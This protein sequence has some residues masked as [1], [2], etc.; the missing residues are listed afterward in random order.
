MKKYLP[1]VLILIIIVG[2][3]GSA[4]KVSAE[5]YQQCVERT[6]NLPIDTNV[7]PCAGLQ[8][9]PGTVINNNVT[10]ATPKTPDP[11]S[12]HL[13]QP[14]PGVSGDFSPGPTNALG[15]YL[16]S[17][18]TLFIGLCAVVAVV[19]IVIGGIEW[20][21]SELISK[22][23]AA[24]E[25]IW[26]AV[27]GLLLALGSYALL[28][29][30]NPD[31]LNTN[32]DIG[33]VTI[34]STIEQQIK[35][36]VDIRTSGIQ[37]IDGKPGAKINFKAEA[38]PV[39]LAVEGTT[40]V[41]AAYLLAIFDQESSSGSMAFSGCSSSNA[42]CVKW[43]PGTGDEQKLNQILAAIGKTSPVNVSP[44]GT[45]GGAYGGCMGY[46]QVCPSEWIRVGGLGK[47]PWNL[48]DSMTVAANL[49]VRE[50]GYNQNPA[51]SVCKYFGSCGGG[52]L[53]NYQASVLR[54]A[55]AFQDRINK[56]DCSA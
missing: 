40:G 11:A 48:N 17:M 23:E 15:S 2:F 33:D 41:K 56:G 21:T 37:T 6:K 26:G 19:M 46:M 52:G 22:K 30:I 53:V 47:N 54:K 7:D 36:L 34:Q 24:K 9:D 12:Y 38:C 55:A 13:L 31:L 20:S 27:L 50:K 16:N 10:P 42:S 43:R 45:A 8:P 49:L 4:L 35:D 3:F 18:I 28:Y 14:L 5:T 1:Y 32:V 29:T 44:G 25:R 39:A 51:Q